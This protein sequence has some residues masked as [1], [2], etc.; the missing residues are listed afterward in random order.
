MTNPSPD[1]PPATGPVLLQSGRTT[2]ELIRPLEQTVHGELLLARRR[3]GTNTADCVVIKRLSR[4]CREEDYRRLMEEVAVTARL[5]HPVIAGMHDVEGTVDDPYLV[6]EHVEGHRL[7]TLL[8]CV[9]EG[10]K[11]L[12]EAFAC[13]V[14]TEVADALDHAH[15]MSTEEGRWLRLVHRNVSPHTLMVGLRG[16]VK[17]TDFGSIWSAL[18]GRQPTEDDALPNTLAYAYASPELT[19]KASIDGRT[20]QF[21]LAAVLLHLVSGRPLIEGS[22]TVTQQLSEL[23][24]RVDEAMAMGPSDPAAV[25]LIQELRGKIH[26]LTAEFVGRIR[27][28]SNRE[29]LEATSMLSTGLRPILRKAL[30][31][32]KTDRYASCE[33]FGHQLRLHLWRIGQLY[34]KP[35]AKRDVAELVRSTA[36]PRARNAAHPA[37]TLELTSQHGAL[38]QARRGVTPAE[39]RRKREAPR[40]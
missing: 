18:P 8:E 31:P 32:K 24:R 23:R 22:D 34:G 5:R 30:S 29:V 11:P 15:E 1:R 10:G 28:L 36:R 9:A 21:S 25:A 40:R 19:K 35:E 37:S 38:A 3:F 12:S 7:D 13:Y 6:L 2:Y 27:A 26:K 39:G 20:D 16:E 33:E 14:G 4:D 17:L